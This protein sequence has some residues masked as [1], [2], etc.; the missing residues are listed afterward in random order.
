MSVETRNIKLLLTV[1]LFACL[2]TLT[3]RHDT[4]AQ[5]PRQSPAGDYPH[6]GVNVDPY[7][8]LDD[9]VA[10]DLDDL[11]AGWVRL[12]FKW[13]DGGISTSDYQAF[14]NRLK[15]RN[16]S[17]LGLVDNTTYPATQ[18][19]WGTTAFRDNFV[20]TVVEQVVRNFE[21]DVDYWEIWN[22]EDFAGDTAMQPA[23]Y[24]KLLGGDP[25]ANPSSQPWARQGMYDA[26]KAEDPG[27]T[28][29]FGGLS[30][31]WIGDGSAAEY[32][33]IFAR[34]ILPSCKTSGM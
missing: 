21:D 5:P 32:L 3:L 16:I 14:I 11:G 7:L 10:D 28:V 25:N 31:S 34:S 9:Y 18:A 12:E 6:K 26:I 19:E 1:L 17:I 2:G 29:L 13:K 8:R 30:N 27:A 20:R 23:D 4:L 33:I 22:E 24:A 15:S